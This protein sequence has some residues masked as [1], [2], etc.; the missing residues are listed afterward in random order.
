MLKRLDPNEYIH[1][2]RTLESAS[3]LGS[4]YDVYLLI[5]RIDSSGDQVQRCERKADVRENG[6]FGDTYAQMRSLYQDRLGTNIGTALKNEHYRFL[7]RCAHDELLNDV[8]R[9]QW[10]FDGFVVSDYDAWCENRTPFFPAP[11][12]LEQTINLPRQARDKYK[13]GKV[14]IKE[15]CFTAGSTSRRP[16]TTRLPSRRPLRWESTQAWTR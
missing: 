2:T 1:V 13:R 8:L 4:I 16:I 12:L 7:L 6:I 15:A 5:P 11:F 9:K 3:V 14:R 10:S